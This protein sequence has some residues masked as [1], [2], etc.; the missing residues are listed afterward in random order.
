M[1]DQNMKTNSINC[2]NC[3]SPISLDIDHLSK[4]CNQCGS[5]IMLDVDTIQQLLI[6]KEKT[7]QVEAKEQTK[8]RK[9][10]LDN[11]KKR[12]DEKTTRIIVIGFLGF[13]TL[14][15]IIIAI[16]KSNGA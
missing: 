4:F 12:E 1:R 8:K 16:A 6:E 2:P 9:A 5:K 13:L 15:F 11:E 3:G 14:I 7:K 10:E